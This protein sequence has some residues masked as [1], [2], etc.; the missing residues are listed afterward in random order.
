MIRRTPPTTRLRDT[1]IA[2]YNQRLKTST[3][4]EIAAASGLSR[5]WLLNFGR[6]SLPFPSVN[7]VE[8]LYEYL[9]GRQIEL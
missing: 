6:G 9:T 7:N 5:T 3:R 8:C 4:D 2:L 1:T